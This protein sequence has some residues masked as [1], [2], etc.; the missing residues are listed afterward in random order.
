MKK[1]SIKIKIV[2]GAAALCVLLSSTS[3]HA[4]VTNR[5]PFFDGL[6]LGPHRVGFM[7]FWERDRTRTWRSAV[8]P[9]ARMI[10]D[11]ARP[12]RMNVW[13]PAGSGGTAML[14]R[15]YIGSA[16]TPGLA[17]EEKII[18]T[19]DLGGAGRGLH[20][21]FRS[22]AVLEEFMGTR[23][24]AFRDAT[25]S[26]RGSYPV[27]VYSLGQGNYTQENIPLCEYL[28]S[29]GFIVVSVPTLG[30]SLRRTT[31]FVHD[32][33]SY[34]NQ[35]RDMAFAFAEVVRRFPTA[36]R[37]RVASV[38]MS[39]GGVYALLFAMQNA[40]VR[41]VVGL[42]PSFL[43]SP[44]SYFYKYWES[45]Q[46]DP[47]RFRGSLLA[48][49]RGDSRPVGFVLDSLHYADRTIIAVDSSVHADFNGYPAYSRRANLA[50]LD[51]FAVA[52]RTQEQGFET[53]KG[54]S[55]YVVCHLKATLDSLEAVPVPC[56]QISRSVVGVTKA[57]HTLT[58]EELYDAMIGQGLSAAKNQV[59]A[60]HL[61]RP[62]MVRIANEL[63]YAGRLKTAAEYA[64]LIAQAFPD[65]A[66]FERLGDAWSSAGDTAAARRAYQRALAIAPDNASV[67][68]KI[69]ALKD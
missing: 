54:V 58:E 59:I 44:P 49:H 10:A 2:S 41:T 34:E 47:A 19:D 48:I 60:G 28:A 26:A 8:D 5:S 33:P 50:E 53:F 29:H 11:P 30:T 39:M 9:S 1:W 13:Y 66:S 4:Q 63:G 21:L 37:Q 6:E 45:P 7:S 42:D 24:T 43:A 22:S 52:R 12:V 40:A 56:G 57:A 68:G 18:S 55:R 3:A 31:M 38:G 69:E 16:R 15:D 46:F 61:R 35:V 17:A 20:G 64:E 62:V 25:P 23:M 65:A 27:I 51:P 36:D 14:F 67:K 32:Q